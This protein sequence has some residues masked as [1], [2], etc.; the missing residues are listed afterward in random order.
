MQLYLTLTVFLLMILLSLLVLGKRLSIKANNVLPTFVDTFLL[1]G[2]LNHVFFFSSSS[3]CF[4]F[5]FVVSALVLCSVIESQQSAEPTPSQCFCKG[6]AGQSK[7][8]R[9]VSLWLLIRLGRFLMKAGGWLLCLLMNNTL[10]CFRYGLYR[11]LLR[12][13]V[14]FRK[15]VDFLF[16]WIVIFKPLCLNMLLISCFIVSACFGGRLQV[17]RPSSLY[18]P[19]HRYQSVLTMTVDKGQLIRTFPPRLASHC[20]IE[21]RCFFCLFI[22]VFFYARV[23][24]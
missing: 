24:S 5:I 1:N 2:R 22:F 14:T 19:T 23:C 20:D 13:R 8:C 10:F 17:A 16:V 3:F 12:S 11:L 7:H 6:G 4:C 9:S 21:L 18:R 15:S